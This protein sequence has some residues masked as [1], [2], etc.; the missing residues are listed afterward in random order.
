M[1]H[2]VFQSQTPAVTIMWA[3]RQSSICLESRPGG[4]L[5][6]VIHCAVQDGYINSLSSVWGQHWCV[7]R[8]GPPPKRGHVCQDLREVAE[9]TSF[10]NDALSLF[11]WICFHLLSYL[12]A[13]VLMLILAGSAA[14]G[15][16]VLNT[17]RDTR[18]AQVILTLTLTLTLLL[19]QHCVIHFPCFSGESWMWHRSTELKKPRRDCAGFD[20]V[21][22]PG[23]RTTDEGHLIEKTFPD[24]SLHDIY[25]KN[26]SSV[27][28]IPRSVLWWPWIQ[29]REHDIDARKR[30]WLLREKN[31]NNWVQNDL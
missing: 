6:T 11:Y 1:L 17:S 31:Y 15:S 12:L 22:L 19:L 18:K 24:F 10:W 16:L 25:F 9:E 29:R 5:C 2:A 13:L 20:D 8:G 23:R 14:R 26:E 27:V 30:Y 4:Q 28:S 7:L 3:D 21:R